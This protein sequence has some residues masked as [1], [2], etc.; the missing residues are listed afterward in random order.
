[1]TKGEKWVNQIYEGIYRLRLPSLAGYRGVMSQPFLEQIGFGEFHRE[2]MS[3]VGLLSEVV[4]AVKRNGLDS[5][6]EKFNLLTLKDNLKG[7]S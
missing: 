5:P 6:G 7:I 1:M 2:S 3:Q 4:G